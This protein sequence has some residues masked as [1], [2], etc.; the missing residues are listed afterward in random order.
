MRLAVRHN[1]VLS[2]TVAGE[3]DHGAFEAAQYDVSNDLTEG[4]TTTVRLAS[5][6]VIELVPSGLSVA[7]F[8]RLA[9]TGA[10]SVSINSGDAVEC[11]V[12]PGMQYAWFIASLAAGT[13]VEVTNEAGQTITVVCT[14]AGDPA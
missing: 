4:G 5:A 9:A 1:L 12:V 7:R 2:S 3:K 6:G 8:L 10:F 14:L 13:S 11:A